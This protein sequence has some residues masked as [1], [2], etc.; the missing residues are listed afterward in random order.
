MRKFYDRVAPGIYDTFDGPAMLPLIAPRPLLAVNGGTD[1][2]TPMPGLQQCA[3]AA[4]AA[5]T[6]AGAENNFTLIIQPATGHRVNPD[7]MK[8]IHEWLVRELKP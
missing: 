8:F 2:R 5:Y 4:R 6:A 7:S 1:I 3:D